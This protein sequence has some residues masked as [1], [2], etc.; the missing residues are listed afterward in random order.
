MVILWTSACVFNGTFIRLVN[1]RRTCY[2]IELRQHP[3]WRNSHRF[4]S[5]E[6]T[7]FLRHR[8]FKPQKKH[9]I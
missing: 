5:C 6:N 3:R 8:D 1:K 4:K 7:S 2:V 9:E